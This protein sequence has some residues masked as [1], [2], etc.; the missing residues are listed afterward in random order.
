MLDFGH[1]ADCLFQRCIIEQT[2]ADLGS[3]SSG[4][5]AQAPLLEFVLEVDEQRVVSDLHILPF[6]IVL[7][8]WF[9]CEALSSFI[10]LVPRTVGGFHPI[11]VVQKANGNQTPAFASEGYIEL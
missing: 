1:A 6:D 8:G 11:A 2:L 7:L 10:M 4:D 5:P 3:F 9:L